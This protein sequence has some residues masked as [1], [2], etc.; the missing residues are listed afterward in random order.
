MGVVGCRWMIFHVLFEHIL[1]VEGVVADWTMV[2]IQGSIVPRGDM[3]VKCFQRSVA[4]RAAGSW[5]Q[6]T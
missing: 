5:I 2:R 1:F 3:L 4:F 6:N